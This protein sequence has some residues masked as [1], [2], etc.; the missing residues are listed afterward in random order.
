MITLAI[1]N[2]NVEASNRSGLESTL[3]D[4]KRVRI[5][6][7]EAPEPT[8]AAMSETIMTSFK[9]IGLRFRTFNTLNFAGYDREAALRASARIP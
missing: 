3:S 7:T 6:T 5:M 4:E 1:G 9:R 2:I 8:R